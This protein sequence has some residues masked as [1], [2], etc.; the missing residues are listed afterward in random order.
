MNHYKIK[1]KDIYQRYLELFIIGTLK[2]K[3]ADFLT[4]LSECY[5]ADPRKVHETLNNLL[6]KIIIKEDNHYKLKSEIPMP[7]WS[8]ARTDTLRKLRKLPEPDPLS[9]QWWFDLDT[10]VLLSKTIWKYVNNQPVFLG[11]PILGY[12]YSIATGKKCTVLDTDGTVLKALNFP[13][14]AKNI[15]YNVEDPIPA[16]LRNKFDLVV[17]DPPWYPK[18]LEL[19]L[20]QSRILAKPNSLILFIIPSLWTRPKEAMQ[21]NA[22]LKYLQRDGFKILGIDHN[23]IGYSVPLFEAEAYRDIKDFDGRS[24][25]RAD[26]LFA[27]LP[28]KAVKWKYKKKRTLG[29]KDYCDKNSN[30]RVFLR[31]NTVAPGSG[32]YIKEDSKFSTSVS[33]REAPIGK[34]GFWTGGKRGFI[35]REPHIFEIILQSWQKGL[36]RKKTTNILRKNHSNAQDIMT[37]FCSQLNL[38]EKRTTKGPLQYGEDLKV[39]RKKAVSSTWASE[40]SNK[41]ND[42]PDR[43]HIKKYDADPFRLEFQRD[44]D[45][46]MWSKSFKRL[47]GK[48]QVFPVEHDEHIR[49]RLTHSLTVCQLAITVAKAFRLDPDLTEAIALAHDIGHPPFGHAGEEAIDYFLKR[50]G[51]TCGFNHYENGVD[52]LHFLEN[53]YL[54]SGAGGYTGLNLCKKVYEG[55]FKH[56][57]YKEEGHQNQNE[58]YRLSKH[59]RKLFYNDFCHLEGQAVRIADKISYMIED[60]E[61][62]IRSGILSL[63]RIIEC[64]LFSRP[65]IDL[66]KSQN[67]T[68]LERFISQR[69][70]ILNVIM[71]DLLNET[72]RNLSQKESIRDVRKSA[73]YS[74]VL[75]QELV[76]DM[77]EIWGKLQ[78]DI[79]F[80]D[81]R[82]Q[83][84]NNRASKVIHELLVLFMFCPKL[85]DD[86]FNRTYETM[87]EQSPEYIDWYK[88]LRKTKRSYSSGMITVPKEFE[89]KYGSALSMDEKIKP[90]RDQYPVPIVNIIRAKDY[91]V[92][93]TDDKAVRIYRENIQGIVPTR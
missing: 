13:R 15:K 34:I 29:V 3:K 28:E 48:A 50:L 67:E 90:I 60:I 86:E 63:D 56:M 46:I 87:M 79:L 54:S 36:S 80:K 23:I 74:I 26:L 61:D 14:H 19:F 75:S 39:S 47:L 17:I 92:S 24:W 49:R 51:F 10:L 77:T 31:K 33:S 76:N 69:R 52:V 43:V 45:R 68:D 38:W 89:I 1:R 25:R 62:G 59:K 35:I 93:L 2:F 78:K 20:I 73:N 21:R 53:A 18:L 83:Q 72:N 32:F 66:K 82:V 42:K 85:I 6:K 7:D 71:E 9:C 88:K 5:G 40:P 44:R 4:L 64:R 30:R 91:V 81:K 70:A 11:T 58:L 84:A 41:E 16:K 55:V 12:F 57:Y 37:K 8:K 27:I 65:R 22:M